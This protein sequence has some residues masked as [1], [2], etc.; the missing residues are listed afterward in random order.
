MFPRSLV[1]AQPNVPLIL[2]TQDRSV[3]T[4]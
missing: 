2:V 1:V 4:Y 3:T